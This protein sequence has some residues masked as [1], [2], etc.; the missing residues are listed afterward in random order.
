MIDLVL[1][2]AMDVFVSIVGF[3]LVVGCVVIF[4]LGFGVFMP[5]G[6]TSASTKTT[7]ICKQCGQKCEPNMSVRDGSMYANLCSW[8]CL[9]ALGAAHRL[10]A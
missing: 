4:L 6:Q 1:R 8:E 9:M 10:H 5:L 7:V 3:V 2:S